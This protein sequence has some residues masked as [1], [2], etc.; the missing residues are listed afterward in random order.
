MKNRNKIYLKKQKNN[1]L[2]KLSVL[3][4]TDTLSKHNKSS[5]RTRN[6][7]MSGVTFQIFGENT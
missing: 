4:Y 7:V 3:G 6:T 1:F 5:R 2:K